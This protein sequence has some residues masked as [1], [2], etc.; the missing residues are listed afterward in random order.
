VTAKP[1]DMAHAQGTAN[2]SLP[3]MEMEKRLFQ[4]GIL[5]APWWVSTLLLFG[6]LEPGY[7]H[8]YH[9]ASELGAFGAG[10]PLAMNVVCFFMTGALVALSGLGFMRYLRSR[11]E[12]RA[13][14]SWIL[15][16]GVMLAGA[17]VP[18]DMELYFQSP[19]TVAHAFFVLLGVVPF[20]VA[21][22][23]T[24]AVLRRLGDPSRFLS[25]FPWLILP[26][27]LLHGFLSQGGL[28]QRLTILIVLV[29]VSGLSWHLLKLARPRASSVQV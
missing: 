9:A 24:H 4:L 22:W 17:A 6:A 13:A 14:G 5:A 25:R 8:L 23:K 7:S 1:D 28:V 20:L 10:N 18:A 16:L 19:W 29:W 15:V 26:A 3:A 12:S 11:G 21:A 27:F 2:G